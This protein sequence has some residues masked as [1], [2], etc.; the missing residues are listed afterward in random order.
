[1]Y[2]P[3]EVRAVLDFTLLCKLVRFTWPYIHFLFVGPGLCLRLPSDSTSRWTPLPSANSSCC[4]ACRGLSPPSYRPCWAHIKRAETRIRESPPLTNRCP[5]LPSPALSGSGPG[6]E[7]VLFRP[8]S[9][10]LSSQP[11]SP[12]VYFQF[13]HRRSF[14]RFYFNL[15]FFICQAIDSH[16]TLEKNAAPCEP[17]ERTQRR[18]TVISPKK[19]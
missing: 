13:L 6:V 19:R 7:R 17:D 16:R 15:T 10:S 2:L 8:Y 18:E 4:Q 14:K 12:G 9:A 11:S 3:H 5:S 1:V